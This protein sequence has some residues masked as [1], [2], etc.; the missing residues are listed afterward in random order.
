MLRR[1]TEASR[2]RVAMRAGVDC[3]AAGF[4]ADPLYGMPCD[5]YQLQ[6]G[7]AGADGLMTA[8]RALAGDGLHVLP[9]A[10]LHVTVL[11]LIEATERLA[12]EKAVLW[13]RHGAA[14]Q[15]AIAAAWARTGPLRLRFGR[16]RFDAR[17]VIVLDE[18]NPLAGLRAALAGACGL[19]ERP[20]RLP[21]I[22]HATLLRV[23]A[24][25]RVRLPA[26]PPMLSVEVAVGALRLVRE[27][28]FPSLAFE[29]LAEFRP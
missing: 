19:P 11:P 16:L 26:T 9:A 14:W 2:D 23:R 10:A 7:L 3:A 5:S 6:I 21:G 24:P 18:A 1:G 25:E 28:T 29:T 20:V 17:T 8:Q 13:A 15:A 4:E 22:T 12:E 27:T